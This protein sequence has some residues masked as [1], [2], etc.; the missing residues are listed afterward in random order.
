VAQWLHI[1]GCAP[2]FV[3]D[4]DTSKLQLAADM[5]FIPINSAEV[6]PVTRIK[7]ESQGGVQKVVEACGLPQTFLQAVQTAAQ[8]GEIVFLGNINGTF[9]IGEKDFSSILRRELVIYGTW[10]SRIVPRGQDEWTAVLD[11][12]DRG[13]ELAPLISHTPDLEQGP[14]LFRAIAKGD[15]PS[16]SK[17][18]FKI[19]EP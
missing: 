2:V 18:I 9:S 1:R 6:D 19:F 15:L 4:I 11:F 17:V 10:N 14:E 5:G 3:A 7:E 8:F 16:Y 13:L 12:M